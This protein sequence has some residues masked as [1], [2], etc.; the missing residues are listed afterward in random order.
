[1]GDVWEALWRRIYPDKP[2][3]RPGDQPS[4]GLFEGRPVPRW[5]MDEALDDAGKA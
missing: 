5:M 1:M 4:G 3:P 2:M